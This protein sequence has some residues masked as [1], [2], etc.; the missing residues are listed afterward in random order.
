MAGDIKTRFSLEGEQEFRSAMTNAAN[1]VKV[2]NAEQKLAKAS[3]EQTGN[4]EKYAAQQADILKQKIEAQKKA[5]QAAEQ[6][7]KQLSDNGV[8]ENSRQFQQWQTKLLNAQ[9][10]LTKTETELQN[11]DSTMQQTTGSAGELSAGI[12]SIG[13]KLSL[14]QVQ[15]GIQKITTG[16]ENAAKKAVELGEKLWSTI[17]DSAARADDTATMAQMYGIDIDTFERMQKLVAG[18]L[19]TS[20]EAILKAQ[21]KMTKG[22]GK[23]SKEVMDVLNELHITMREGVLDD[24][25]SWQQKDPQKL[26]WEAGQAIMAMGDAYDKEAAAQALFGKSWKELVPLFETYK[27]LDE[28]NAALE[29]Q[30]VNSAETVRDLAALNDAVGALESSW[31]TLKEELIGAIAPALTEAATAA[32]GLLDKLTEYLQTDEGQAMLSQLGDAVSDLLSGITKLSADDV[33]NGFK[34]ALNTLTSSLTWISK[35][36]DD[37]VTAL[38]AIAVAFAGLKL[39]DI[40]ISIG[41]IVSGFQTLWGGAGN[42]LPTMP[43]GNSAGGGGDAAGTAAKG[44]FFSAAATKVSTA[45]KAFLSSGMLESMG[46]A[47]VA[48]LPAI[49]AN[50]AYQ[51][52]WTEQYNT[53]KEA[54]A[55]GGKY[56]WF[57]DAAADALDARSGRMDMGR[58]EELLNGLKDL[59]NQQKAELINTLGQDTWQTLN[60][61]WENPENFDMIDVDALMADITDKFAAADTK[62]ELPAELK[63]AEDAAASVSEQVGTVTLPARLVWDGKSWGAGGLGG[64]S[65]MTH[66]N[67]LPWVPYDGYLALLHQGE[68]VLTASQNRSYT[69]NSNNYFGN[70]NLNNGQDIDALCDRIDRRNRRMQTGYGS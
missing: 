55:Q 26:F 20:V 30:T 40:A 18:G 6:A 29:E 66:A 67:G 69:Y 33:V 9:T 45:A 28:Y 51:K 11:L 14:D 52:Q 57:I 17:M 44:G 68:R 70:V 54:A 16:L 13:K 7:L 46:V 38:E 59:Q 37:L 48:L 39:A 24:W 35:N 61:Y 36:K 63:A 43:G 27:T 49:L 56:S 60:K 2:L 1:A 3:F 64:S 4:A 65:L 50:S 58:Q 15:S 8:S 19:D 22:V 62:V 25:T 31:T 10:A 47:A 42:P 41:K 32:G 34:D 12:S 5:V 53:R 21:D 23:G